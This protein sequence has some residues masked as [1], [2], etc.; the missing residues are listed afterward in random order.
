[1]QV[2]LEPFNAPVAAAKVAEKLL[3]GIIAEQEA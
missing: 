1:M 3:E 2:V